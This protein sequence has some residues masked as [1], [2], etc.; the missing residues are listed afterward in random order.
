MVA[1]GV[2][3]QRIEHSSSFPCAGEFKSTSGS[4]RPHRWLSFRIQ[5]LQCPL[6]SLQRRAGFFRS[7]YRLGIWSENA[8]QQVRLLL[9]RQMHSVDVIAYFSNIR[10]N[11]DPFFVRYCV[12][13]KNEFSSS[14][15]ARS[16]EFLFL[17]YEEMVEANGLQRN[18]R[19][20]RFWDRLGMSRVTLG[21]PDSQVWQRDVDW[22]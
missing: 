15:V 20:R 2:F 21:A 19:N 8:S 12:V 7:P 16:R 10:L 3:K 18:H 11:V 4:S 22:A 17:V 14:P 9:D 6:E 13:S 1:L 5:A